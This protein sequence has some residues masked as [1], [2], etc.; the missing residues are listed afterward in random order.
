VDFRETTQKFGKFF[1]RD[2]L[3]T[4]VNRLFGYF[5]RVFFNKS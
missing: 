2:N 3:Y 1:I 4:L 5:L